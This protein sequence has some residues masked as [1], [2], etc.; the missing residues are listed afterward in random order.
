MDMYNP[1]H[2]CIRDPEEI[3]W[4]KKYKG[5]KIKYDEILEKEKSAEYMALNLN[6]KLGELL[7]TALNESPTISEFIDSISR[8][9]RK[10]LRA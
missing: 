7:V 1:K 10:I 9:I 2:D 3:D 6:A 8:G 4:E 5:L